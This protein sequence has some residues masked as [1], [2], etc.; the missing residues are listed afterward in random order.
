MKRIPNWMIMVVTAACLCGGCDRGEREAARE[1]ER[2][3]L[4]M[5]ESVRRETE[6]AHQAITDMNKRLFRKPA[7][8]DPL[9]REEEAVEPAPEEIESNESAER[10][11]TT[12]E[13][14]I[15]PATE[16]ATP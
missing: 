5:E 14:G 4:E 9:L 6:A 16:N 11:E 12:G 1:R 2:Q 10:D 15:V 8:E 3:R 13:T 7:A